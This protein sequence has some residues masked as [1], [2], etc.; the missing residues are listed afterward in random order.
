MILS[1]R[2]VETVGKEGKPET[3]RYVNLWHVGNNAFDLCGLKDGAPPYFDAGGVGNKKSIHILVD[4]CNAA[5]VDLVGKVR[6]FSCE[7]MD[8]DFQQ[9]SNALF[10]VIG[11]TDVEINACMKSLQG[12][13][14]G[15]SSCNC[16]WI[17]K[18]TEPF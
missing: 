14:T 8:K 5:K 17:A 15:G 2:K 18:H 6:N 4:E 12:C 13:Y 9:S 11:Y 10:S 7:S 1:I 3:S 16:T